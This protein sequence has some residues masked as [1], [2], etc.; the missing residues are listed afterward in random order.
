[1][2]AMSETVSKDK[3]EE[4]LQIVVNYANAQ[5]AAAVDLKHRVAQLVGVKAAPAVKEEA[6]KILKW[7]KQTGAK[8]GEYEVAYQPNNLPEKWNYAYGILQKNN[9]TISSRYHGEGYA[10][11]YWLYGKGKIYRQRLKQA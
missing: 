9:A 8:I 5:E 4:A 2:K 6:F 1:M 10:Y 3:F 7:E 11:S